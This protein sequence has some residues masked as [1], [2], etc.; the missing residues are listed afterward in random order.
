VYPNPAG[1][2]VTLKFSLDKEVPVYFMLTDTQGKI[3]Q[4]VP[5]RNVKQGSNEIAIPFSQFP[6]EYSYIITL[7]FNHKFSVSKKI[8][9]N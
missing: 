6:S 1:N 8:T 2:S 3:H 9:K 5:L 4:Q 7:V